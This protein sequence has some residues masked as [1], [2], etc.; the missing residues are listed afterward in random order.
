MPRSPPQSLPPA[1]QLRLLTADPCRGAFCSQAQAP[2]VLLA[3]PPAANCSSDAGRGRQ[4]R[5]ATNFLPLHQLSLSLAAAKLSIP[6]KSTLFPKLQASRA[7][8]L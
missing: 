1:H 3:V 6:K 5:R 8:Q 7:L 2:H 4:P